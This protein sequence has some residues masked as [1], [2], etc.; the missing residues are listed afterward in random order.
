MCVCVCACVMVD[1]EYVHLYIYI[2]MRVYIYVCVYIYVYIYIHIYIHIYTC[3][4][5]QHVYIYI[6][7]YIYIY[8]Q[9]IKLIATPRVNVHAE[10]RFA[11]TKTSS[12]TKKSAN[13]TENWREKKER[14]Q[15]QLQLVV[16]VQQCMSKTSSTHPQGASK[17]VVYAARVR[18]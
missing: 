11:P 18:T 7:T 5:P 17:D 14:P 1:Y 13:A 4:L 16:K 9:D 10:K 15:Q 8:I 12:R 3:A 6:Y 2:Y